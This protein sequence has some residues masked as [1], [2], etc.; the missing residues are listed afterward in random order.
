M[1]ANRCNKQQTGYDDISSLVHYNIHWRLVTQ[2]F[3]WNLGVEEMCGRK[4]RVRRRTERCLLFPDKP[5]STIGE[6]A[7]SASLDLRADSARLA[8]LWIST[9]Q[10]TGPEPLLYHWPMELRSTS[11]MFEPGD[12]DDP[13]GQLS[14][15]V[16]GLGTASQA[17]SGPPQ[18]PQDLVA[19]LG[20]WEGSLAEV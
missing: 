8:P 6:Y 18:S 3:H 2:S 12:L 1:Y 10:Q 11:R 13:P 4:V 14:G 15:L 16:R 5:S 9:H 7:V 17:G 19:E 20:L